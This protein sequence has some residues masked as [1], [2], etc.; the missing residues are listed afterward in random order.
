VGGP[1]QIAGC[2]D[3]DRAVVPEGNDHENAFGRDVVVMRDH[4]VDGS[5]DAFREIGA[6][7]AIGNRFVQSMCSPLSRVNHLLCHLQRRIGLQLFMHPCKGF[8]LPGCLVRLLQQ[9]EYRSG[10]QVFRHL[11]AAQ[12]TTGKATDLFYRE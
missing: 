9:L 12:Q 2:P 3:I 8:Y 5:A 7:A 6:A 4:T 1:E 11:S 10:L